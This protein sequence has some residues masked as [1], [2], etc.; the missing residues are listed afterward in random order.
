MGKPTAVLWDVGNVIVRWDP[1]LLYSK[2][3]PDPAERDRFLAE[4]CTMSWHAQNDLALT[5]DPAI[6]ALA[7]EHPRYRDQIAAWRDRWWEM[8]PGAIPQTEEAIAALHARGVRQF[9]LT[10]LCGGDIAAGVFDMTPAFALLDD[11][12]VSGEEGVIKPDRRIYD[13]VL[14]RTGLQPPDLLFVDD[15]PANIEA[16]KALGFDTHLFAEPTALRPA[17]EARGLL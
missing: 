10:N 6:E 9:G 13:I 11:I 15:S 17:L 1:R 7:A 12:V 14:E 16:A 8:F 3:F 4:V 2:I 5:M